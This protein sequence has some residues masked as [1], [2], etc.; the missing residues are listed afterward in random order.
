MARGSSP[1]P[2]HP[3]GAAGN[4]PSSLDLLWLQYAGISLSFF[5]NRQPAGTWFCHDVGCSVKAIPEPLLFLLTDFL[6]ISLDQWKHVAP[7]CACHSLL[8]RRLLK[9]IYRK[10]KSKGLSFGKNFF[11]PPSSSLP[12]GR[13]P[14]LLLA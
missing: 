13:S 10:D 3:V 5:Q 1:A 12:F 2:P 6:F 7:C 4:A 14:L 11:L 8:T 9:L